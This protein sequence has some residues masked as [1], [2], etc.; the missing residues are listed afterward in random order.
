M[1]YPS[2][3]IGKAVK[4]AISLLFLC[5]C[6]TLFTAV[7]KVKIAPDYAAPKQN[8]SS[9]TAAAD[10]Q[11]EFLC[12]ELLKENGIDYKRIEVATNIDELSGIY[13]NSITV[14]TDVDENKVVEILSKVVESNRVKVVYE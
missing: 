1:F 10:I 4:Y 2:G 6:V 9:V 11:A 8:E 3:N 14:Y 5:I 13:I 12:A 7:G